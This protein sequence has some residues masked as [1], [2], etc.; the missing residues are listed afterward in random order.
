MNSYVNMAVGALLGTIFVLMSVSI[1]SEGIFHAPTPEKEGFAIVAETSGADS[2]SG[3]AAA[4]A[5][6]IAT[7][8]ASADAAKGETVFKKCMS[9]HTGES[10]GPNKVGPNLYDVVNRP[11]ASHAGFS[12]SAGMK[13]FSKGS[14]EKWDYDHL[15]YF[16]EAPK[17]HVPGTAM[18]FAGIKKETERADLIAYLRTLSANPAP[19]P[20][21]AAAAPAPAP[22]ATN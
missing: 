20:D 15:S 2:G 13:D 5:T 22:A 17:K 10:G 7:L 4:V 6:P 16:I 11:I 9:C 21:P 1:A 3:E 19:L 14:T 12:Y 8:L 18:G